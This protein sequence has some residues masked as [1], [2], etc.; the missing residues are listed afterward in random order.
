MNF[1]PELPYVTDKTLEEE[2]KILEEEFEK[3]EQGLS[4]GTIFSLTDIFPTF[5]QSSPS[6]L[7]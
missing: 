2:M 5:S 7:P 4:E 6:F 3:V 1:P